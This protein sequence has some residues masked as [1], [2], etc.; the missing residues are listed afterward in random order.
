MSKNLRANI[1]KA[2][3][4]TR[5]AIIDSQGRTPPDY[6]SAGNILKKWF[7]TLGWL[8]REDDCNDLK[9]VMCLDVNTDFGVHP[10]ECCYLEADDDG[11]MVDQHERYLVRCSDSTRCEQILSELN[12]LEQ[13]YRDVPKPLF[14]KQK[15]TVEQL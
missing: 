15:T 11:F 12:K 4:Q 5:D 1:E 7:E 8:L 14:K 6:E 13:E 3:E 2:F 9:T 10:F